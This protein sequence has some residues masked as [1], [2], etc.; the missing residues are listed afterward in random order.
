MKGFLNT[1][2]IEYVLSH[3]SQS[4]DLSEEIKENFVFVKSIEESILYKNK[5]IFVLHETAFDISDLLY[6]NDLPVL[7]TNSKIN[8][9]YKI[10]ND[11]IFDIN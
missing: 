9:F 10:E 4:I 8:E 7:F 5:I 3:L 6:I 2:Q 11:K 1:N